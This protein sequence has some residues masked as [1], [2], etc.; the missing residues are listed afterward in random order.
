MSAAA[1]LHRLEQIELELE[2]G[3]RELDRINNVLSSDDAVSAVGARFAAERNELEEVKRRQKH[4]EWE[5][6]DLQ[7]KARQ[8]EHKLYSG[9]S[10][11]P[12]ELVNLE[13][14]AKGLKD[15]IRA[16]E[17]ELLE[18]M[19]RREEVEARL[20]ETETQFARVKQEWE[21]KRGE[22][23]Q[24]KGEIE[25][26]VARL[27][28]KREELIQ[29]IDPQMLGF[30][31]QLKAEKGTAVVKVERGRCQGCHITLPTSQWQKAKAGELIRCNSCN[32][33]LYV[34]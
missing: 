4:L 30:Y 24:R 11:N 21:Q 34:E 33:I 18:V 22:L 1:E 6:E 28:Q 29:R 26:Q 10:K 12:K 13:K 32:R 31:R 2:R 16:K 17:D 27:K 19:A 25:A 20:K 5:V 8:I 23:E 3:E 14:E 15:R 7:E 9:A